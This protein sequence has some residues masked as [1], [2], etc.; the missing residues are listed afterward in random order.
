MAQ[1]CLGA[2]KRSWGGAGGGRKSKLGGGRSRRRQERGIQLLAGMLWSRMPG[3]SPGEGAPLALPMENQL[4]LHPC[5]TRATTEDSE[6]VTQKT[7][8]SQ[9]SVE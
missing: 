2:P 3:Q 9:C 1:L 8:R 6:S 7:H 5:S 4:L